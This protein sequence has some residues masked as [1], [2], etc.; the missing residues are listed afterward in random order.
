MEPPRR[1]GAP[2]VPASV[3]RTIQCE[4][5]SS[6]Y[7]YYYKDTFQSINT[8]NWTQNG[9]LSVPPTWG[10]S[11]PTSEAGRLISKVPVQGPSATNYAVKTTLALNTSGGVYVKYLRATPNALAGTGSYYSVEPQN[12]TFNATTG[13]CSATLAGLSVD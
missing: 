8:T 12:P 2:L 1:S 13:A 10:L 5:S 3:A 9:T 4:S 11:A 6:G 7:Q